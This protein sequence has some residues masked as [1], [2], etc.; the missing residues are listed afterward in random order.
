MLSGSAPDKELN[1]EGVRFGTELR[2]SPFKKEL[3]RMLS[4][5][6]STPP[7]KRGLNFSRSQ[8]ERVSSYSGSSSL[9]ADRHEKL[10]QQ[11]VM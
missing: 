3:G 11:P 5:H 9:N 2:T 1:E 7:V 10:Q 8:K 4:F 6:V